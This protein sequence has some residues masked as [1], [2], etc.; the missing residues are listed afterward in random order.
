MGA[1][2]VV[3]WLNSVFWNCWR[4]NSRQKT[5]TNKNKNDKTTTKM[6]NKNEIIA[7]PV[8]LALSVPCANEMVCTSAQTLSVPCVSK[9]V[10]TSADFV[11]WISVHQH[12]LRSWMPVSLFVREHRLCQLLVSVSLCLHQHRLCQ[13]N[14]GEIV[15]TS[16]Q[17]LSA[18]CRW[19]SLH[20]SMDFVQCNPW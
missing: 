11:S 16:A 7:K 3:F 18:E 1:S 8:E 5:T 6:T 4:Q 12:R 2:N 19:A 15:F 9:L 13:L 10:F 17:T 14:V 20:I